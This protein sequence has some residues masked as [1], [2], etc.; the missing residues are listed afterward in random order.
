MTTKRK[1][2]PAVTAAA[3]LIGLVFAGCEQ[4]TSPSG[5]E[6]GEFRSSGVNAPAN[7]D[8]F[9]YGG[10]P[11][12]AAN[13]WTSFAFNDAAT[14]T[15]IIQTVTASSNAS[16]SAAY[17][18]SGGIGT[19]TVTIT[20]YGTYTV[21]ADG[22][23]LTQGTTVYQNLRPDDNPP[24]FTSN[25]ADLGNTIFAGSGPRAPDWCTFSF[26]GISSGG[27][28]GTV[29]ASFTIDNTTNVWTYKYDP[30]S[31]D[32]TIGANPGQTSPGDFSV[33]IDPVSGESIIEFLNYF[34]HA[35]NWTFNR[36]Q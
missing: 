34:G 21:S 19:G 33:Y 11:S 28:V 32:G 10:N 16:T 25:P 6:T 24:V 27:T 9:V 31:G 29:I 1:W 8:N 12:G 14:G 5:T 35:P 23:T 17:T 7:I 18:Y 15:V 3:V 13:T 20:G 2:L 4:L 36:W 22:S 26:R 30:V